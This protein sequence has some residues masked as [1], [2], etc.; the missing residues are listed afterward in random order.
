MD[1]LIFDNPTRKYQQENT[2]QAKKWPIG[3][4]PAPRP[5]GGIPHFQ[6]GL[7]NTRW[8]NCVLAMQL[9]V[10][11]IHAQSVFSRVLI[12]RT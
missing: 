6:A 4:H 10:Y 8:Q 7:K 9:Q 5:F 11:F 12:V 2:F 1:Y 3:A